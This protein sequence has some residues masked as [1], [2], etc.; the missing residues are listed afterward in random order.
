MSRGCTFTATVDL[1]GK[2]ATGI[3]V[4]AEVIEQLGSGQRPAVVVAIGS[5]SYRT[6]A[7][8]RG[9]RHLLPLSAEHRTAAAVEA[10]DE[11]Q[12]TLTLDTAPRVVELPDDLAEA[13]AAAGAREAFDG[14]APSHRKEHARAVA[15]AKKPETRQ[16]RIAKVVE[17]LSG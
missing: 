15:E 3:E 13:L 17:A 10:G 14:L 4:P 7:A 5:Y 16:R 1:G 8:V 2:T 6:T 12:V 11:V 9:G